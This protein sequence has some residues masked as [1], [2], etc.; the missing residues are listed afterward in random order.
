MKFTILQISSQYICLTP[1]ET[2]KAKYTGEKRKRSLFAQPGGQT[3]FGP[4]LIFAL[5]QE[6]V[7]KR[8]LLYTLRNLSHYS[9]L[10]LKNHYLFV[11]V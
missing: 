3:V 4:S 2:V 10:F 5:P 11:K 1:A 9:I 6:D 8:Q 7:Y